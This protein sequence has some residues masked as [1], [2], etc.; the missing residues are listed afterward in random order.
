MV[1]F[2]IAFSFLNFRSG[3]WFGWMG[4]MCCAVLCR[5]MLAVL[6]CTVLYWYGGVMVRS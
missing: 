4:R 3:S 1:C 6:Y 5:A 2:F